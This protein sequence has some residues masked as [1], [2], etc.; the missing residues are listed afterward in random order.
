MSRRNFSC[1]IAFGAIALLSA[2][3]LARASSPAEAQSFIQSYID[4]GVAVLA[5]KSL[6][7]DDRKTQVRSILDKMLDTRRIGLYSIGAAKQAASQA[8]LDAYTATFHDYLIGSYVARLSDYG[9]Q[10]IKVTG[11]ITHGTDD[12]VVEAQF[13]GSNDPNPVKVDV[14][15]LGEKG[16]YAVV[17]ASVAGVWMGSAQQA[18]FVG[19]LSHHGNSVPQLTQHLK[20]V[21]ASGFKAQ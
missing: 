14:R 12:Y 19:Y 8:D 20:D 1:L 21:I 4:Q 17:D 10:A 13:A 11:A 5:N 16:G 7:A 2:A 3:P 6:S 15:V 18:D 9:G